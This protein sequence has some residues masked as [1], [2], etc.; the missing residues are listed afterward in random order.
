MVFCLHAVEEPPPDI[1][2]E[3]EWR[4]ALGLRATHVG[5]VDAGL[6]AFGVARIVTDTEIVIV[7]RDRRELWTATAARD[8]AEASSVQLTV[9]QDAFAS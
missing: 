7:K 5:E 8:D 2:T 6:R 1:G 9:A 3:T 4:A